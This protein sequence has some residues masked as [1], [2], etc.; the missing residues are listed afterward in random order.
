MNPEFAAIRSLD[1]RR[2]SDDIEDTARLLLASHDKVEA[3][4]QKQAFD[5]NTFR[6]LYTDASVD[7]D[8]RYVADRKS[9]F[10]K[11]ADRKI[12][13]ELTEGEVRKLAER[14]EFEVLRGINVGNWIPMM[15]AFKTSE[16][17]DIHWGVDM[18]LEFQN[19]E[20]FGHI[21]LGIDVTF[22]QDIH[23]KFARIKT[24][25]ENFD[26]DKHRLARAKYYE[27][28][29]VGHRGELFNLARVVVAV[30]LPM[31]EDMARAR[32]EM[33][34]GHIARH[35]ILLELEQQ[36]AVFADYAYR[37]N[38]PAL[39]PIQNAQN[40]VHRMVLVM[41]S[42]HQLRQSEYGKNRRANESIQRELEL[43]RT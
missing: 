36:L 11:T 7:R 17:D 1:S 24:E 32:N 9:D 10:A 37:A 41:E 23:K 40:L 34:T 12:A 42:E 15:K 21:G 14:A 38:R 25:I 20:A 18:V 6:D 31:L 13:G 30:D 8:L 16:F 29:K 2:R 43:F 28:S 5:P 35:E 19:R 33:H 26:G 22:A 39:E 27:S 4:M 3:Y